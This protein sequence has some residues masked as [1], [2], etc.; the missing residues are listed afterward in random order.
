M[1]HEHTGKSLTDSAKGEQAI[2][3]SVLESRNCGIKVIENGN[4]TSADQDRAMHYWSYRYG[5]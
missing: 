2:V 5:S 3:H 1:E 4:V